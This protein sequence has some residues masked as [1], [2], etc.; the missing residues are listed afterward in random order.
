MLQRDICKSRACVW[1]PLVDAVMHSYVIACAAL[2]IS[3][4]D[5]CCYAYKNINPFIALSQTV[6]L[7]QLRWV[8]R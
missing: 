3:L 1:M 7:R 8:L 5:W 4:A 2:Y 6:I